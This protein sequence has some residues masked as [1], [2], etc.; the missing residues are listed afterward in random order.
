M[1]LKAVAVESYPTETEGAVVQKLAR[2]STGR[3]GP[4]FALPDC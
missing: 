3:G 4:K 1:P 2:L